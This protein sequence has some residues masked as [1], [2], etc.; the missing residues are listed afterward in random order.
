MDALGAVV[1]MTGLV[2]PPTEAAWLGSENEDEDED[3]EE[4]E[5]QKKE[6][7]KDAWYPEPGPELAPELVS[8]WSGSGCTVPTRPR[9]A[10]VLAIINRIP[11]LVFSR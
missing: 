8:C 10:D 11:G 1:L 9:M 7:K 5:P 4:K 6:K 2:T 3:K